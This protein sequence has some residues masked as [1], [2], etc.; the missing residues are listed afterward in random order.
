MGKKMERKSELKE[1][2]DPERFK[3]LKPKYIS[4]LDNLSQKHRIIT[5]DAFS[6]LVNFKNNRS[7]PRHNWFE[8]KQGYA[9]ELVAKIIEQE[10]PSKT[11]YILDQF[12]GVGTTNLV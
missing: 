10:K 8:Y 4:L 9:E 1:V 12:T 2:I 6:D 11:S 3:V 7:I 5:E